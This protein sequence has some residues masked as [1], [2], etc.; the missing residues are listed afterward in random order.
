MLAQRLDEIQ[1]RT[2][3]YVG[4]QS[5]KG[6]SRF[7]SEE[8]SDNDDATIRPTTESDVTGH[9]QASLKESLSRFTFEKDLRNAKVYS[10]IWGRLSSTSL[11]SSTGRTRG[12]SVLSDL[13]LSMVSNISV[14]SLPI[15]VGELYTSEN[16]TL[17]SR[18]HLKKTGI[19]NK[20][21]TIGTSNMRFTIGMRR[22][23]F[24]IPWQGTGGTKAI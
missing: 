5:T 4:S 14:L 6:T 17:D 16:F 13:D 19:S 20:Q 8:A 10:R 1:V 2:A 18:V 24:F 21:V 11:P 3:S 23:Q 15:S 9:S 12:W 22:Y 7:R